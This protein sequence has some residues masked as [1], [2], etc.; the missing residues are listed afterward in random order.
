MR[1]K[2]GHECNMQTT[3]Y[4]LR[5]SGLRDGGSAEVTWST[6]APSTCS[7]RILT[8][9]LARIRHNKPPKHGHVMYYD[10]AH[11]RGTRS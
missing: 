5:G 9:M 2:N 1:R 8:P 11:S 6:V 3:L 4:P 7:N 10:P